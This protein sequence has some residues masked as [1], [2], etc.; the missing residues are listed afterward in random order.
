[1]NFWEENI[2]NQNENEHYAKFSLSNFDNSDSQE[3]NQ[4]DEEYES[5]NDFDI[6]DIDFSNISGTSKEKFRKI[7]RKTTSAKIVPKKKR[8]SNPDNKTRKIVADKNV[9]Y[10]F[11]RRSGAKTETQI[12]LPNNRE[13]LIE[14]VDKFILSTDQKATAIKNIGY[15]KGEKL[16]ELV[17]IINNTSPTDLDIQLFNPSSPLDYLYSTSNNLNTRILVAGDNKVTYSDLMFNILANPTLIPNAK[18]FVAGASKT[19][20]INQPMIF[21]N[22]NIAGNEKIFPIQNALNIDIDQQQ[23]DILYWDIQKTLGRVYVP[24]GMDIISYKILAGMT[25]IFGFYFK[26]VQIKKVFWEETRNV[27]IL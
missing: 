8:L 5:E 6:T 2:E 7:K 10:K 16:Q 24:D 23:N 14:G 20:Q 11:K 22:K 15:Y 1:M 3:D 25:V 17:L 4:D 27:G 13:V 21:I 18:F 9:A 26:Q 12:R 19:A